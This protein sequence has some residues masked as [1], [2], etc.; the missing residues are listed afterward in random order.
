MC[1]R[2]TIDSFILKVEEVSIRFICHYLT[3]IC[4]YSTQKRLPRRYSVFDSSWR[5]IYRIIRIPKKTNNSWNAQP[6]CCGRKSNAIFLYNQWLLCI[7]MKTKVVQYDES[8]WMRDCE[9]VRV[10]DSERVRVW[11]W[12]YDLVPSFCLTF[13]HFFLQ[14]IYPQKRR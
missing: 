10:I 6:W 8:E 4:Y 11:E 12:E 13:R 5:I 7:D 2:L 9:T 1:H 3:L 14:P